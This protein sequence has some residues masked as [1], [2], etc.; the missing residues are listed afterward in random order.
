MCSGRLGSFQAASKD[1]QAYSS[2]GNISREKLDMRATQ[3]V[4]VWKGNSKEGFPAA[5]RYP[6]QCCQ[7]VEAKGYTEMPCTGI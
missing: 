5:V 7:R 6:E 1:W 3:V 4:T 2:D